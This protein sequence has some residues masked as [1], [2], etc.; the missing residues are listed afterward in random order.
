MDFMT[1]LETNLTAD[2]IRNILTHL[3]EKKKPTRKGEMA[4]RLHDIWRREPRRLLDS[5]SDPERMLLAECTH[6]GSPFPD[7]AQLNAKHG[8]SYSIPH[9]S[10]YGDARAILCFLARDGHW[11]HELVDGVM[12][13]LKRLLPAP[14]SLQIA[15]E[16]DLPAEGTWTFPRWGGQKDVRKRTLQAYESER[17]APLETK[18]MLQ[19]AAS[20]KLRVSDKTGFPPPAIQKVVDAALC[21]PDLDIA[22]PEGEDKP[23]QESDIDPGPVRAFAWPVLLQQCGWAKSRAGKLALTREGRGLLDDFTFERYAKGVQCLLQDSAFDELRRVSVL[24]GQRGRRAGRGRIPVEGRRNAIF[25]C[26]RAL[27]ENRW[28]SIEEANRVLYALGEDGRAYGDGGMCLYIGELQYGHLSGQE[29]DI[30]RIYFRQLI[31]ASLATLGLVDLGYAYPHYLHPELNGSW[32][33][34]DEVYVTR[35]DG[36]K[37]IRVTPLGRFCLGVDSAYDPPEF[38]QRALFKVLPNLDIVVTDTVTFSTAD[39][40]M[41]E[42]FAQRKSDA[43]WKI[44]RKTILSA[45]EAGDD[46]EDILKAL[47]SGTDVDIPVTVSSLVEETAVRAT[48]ATGRQDALVVGFRDEEIAALVAHDSAAAKAIL[49]R[50]GRSVVVYCKKLRAFQSALRKLGILLP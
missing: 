41:L 1:N 21:A 20:E 46:P 15:S 8:F 37:Y 7:V 43:V 10:G 28:V 25:V 26:L 36:V 3:G 12:D 32:G 19:L 48:A 38:E 17:V 44:S 13:D 29:T 6:A 33:L 14:P 24:K 4:Q 22:L 11:G 50:E 9:C 34:D 30:G 47:R 27:P 40:A 35:Y 39:E 45:L 49:C 2:S 5:L 31:S 16:Q 18:R 42:R 23:W